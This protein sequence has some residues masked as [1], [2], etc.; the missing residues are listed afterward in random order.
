MNLTLEI[1]LAR[2]YHSSTQ[3]GRV[4][5]EHWVA[6]QSYCPNCGRIEINRYPNNRPVAD[7]F[8]IGCGEDYELKSS[9]NHF[10]SK[11]NDGAFST[12]IRRLRSAN[13]PNFFL[14]TY[15]LKT[16]KVCD[17]TVIPKHY[18]TPD[19]IERRPPLPETARRAGWEGCFILL[20]RV[21]ESGRIHIIREGHELPKPKVLKEW[22]Q[23]LF[24]REGIGLPEKGWLLDVMRC[25]ESLGKKTFTLDEAYQFEDQ[26][27][28]LHPANRHIKEK[29]RQQ[30]Q[31]LRDA[32]YLLFLGRG[33]YQVRN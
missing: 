8:C 1:A 2:Q 5:S 4:L 32:G 3:K 7:F 13:N 14:M 6:S 31:V 16:L 26:L 25:I 9:K 12:M 24:L 29:I 30:L 22:K 33:K 18:F 19:I 15:V 28:L 27:K 11:I 20:N 17:F 21:P 10:T 23:T